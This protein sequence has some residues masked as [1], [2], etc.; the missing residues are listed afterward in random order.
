[1]PRLVEGISRFFGRVE[2]FALGLEGERQAA[3][4]ALLAGQPLE[5]REH[6]RT[7]VGALPDSPLGLALWAD[8]AED[9]WLDHEAATALHELAKKVPWRADVWLRLARAGRRIDWPGEREALER[10]ATAPDE[11]ESARLALLDLA[12]L[13][14]LAGDPA[15]AQRWLDRIP[16]VLAGEADHEAA[17]RRAECAIARGDL[18]Q[19]RHEVEQGLAEEDAVSGREALVK[20]RLALADGQ[21]AVA[22][23]LALRAF[24]LEADGAGEMLA[25]LLASSQDVMVVERV[26]RVVAAARSLDDPM[27]AAAFAFAEGRRDDARKAL[28][29]GLGK[30]DRSAAAALLALA[31]ETRDLDALHA[32]AARD[33]ALLPAPL[34]ALRDAA[35]AAGEGREREALDRLELIGGDLAGWAAAL[36]RSVFAR[37][38]PSPAADMPPAAAWPELLR[39]LRHEAR[40]LDRL[41][42]LGAVEALAIERERPLRVA[43]VGE[44]N[45]GK[46]TFLNALLGEDVAPTGVLPTTATLHWVAWAP[47]PFARVVVR[48]APDRVVPHAELK[49]TLAALKDTKVERV[50]IYAPIERLKRVEILDTPGFN[51]PDPDHIA[52]ARAAFDEAHVAIWLLDATHPMKETERKVLAEIQD[53][54][55]PV[56]ILANK[57][58]RLKPD[59]RAAVLAHIH[60]G[61]VAVGLRS[62]AEPLAF[63]ARLS[64]KGRMGDAAA[65]AASGWPEVEA[66][67]SEHIVDASEALRERALRRRA[68]RLAGELSAAASARAEEDRERVRAAR[69]RRTAWLEAAARLRRERQA[70]AAAAD[71]A[72]EP[73]RTILRADLKPLG[74]LPEERQR[75]DAGLRDYLRERFVARLADPVVAELSKGMSEPPARAAAAVRAVLM[76]AVASH[77]APAHLL[78]RPLDRVLEA[79]VEAFAV[80]LVTEAEQPAVEAP[81]AAL[82]LRT[83]ALSEAFAG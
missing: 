61:L 8:A 52:A 12:D 77:D 41:D 45:A 26:R 1:M 22:L 83:A 44:F 5:A 48:G 79:A 37:W 24:I 64:L 18:P 53:L 10:A 50:Y 4:A 54:G 68:R 9:A 42:L 51:A 13:D 20:A 65:L 40:S 29:R 59:E 30:G 55:V 39:E 38:L 66:L 36:R 2:I 78:E 43:V 81:S 19:A 67:I 63:S 74:A 35:L 3:E 60:A 21:P 49:A 33:L 57:A 28:A 58:D 15:R 75:S 82:E 23:D 76:G 32:L 16:P 25:Q 17:L 14:L 73:A 71:Q 7:I 80:A 56:Q 62:Q 31:T 6:A 69:A 70:V 47:D 11:R 46:S 72:I 27:W 34:A